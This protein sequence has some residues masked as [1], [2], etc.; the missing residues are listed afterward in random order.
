[1]GFDDTGR[2]RGTLK[3]TGLRPKVVEKLTEA[4]V[5]VDP[6]LFASEKFAR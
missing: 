2:S 3:A 4:G 1:M 5:E 6:R